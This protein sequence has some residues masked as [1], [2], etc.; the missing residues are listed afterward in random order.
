MLN[1]ISEIVNVIV[2]SHEKENSLQC[3]NSAKVFLK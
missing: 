1:G 2:Y 3:S